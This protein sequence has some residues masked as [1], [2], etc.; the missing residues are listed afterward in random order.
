MLLK[1]Y[2]TLE[3][4]VAGRLQEAGEQ[5]CLAKVVLANHDEGGDATSRRGDP[6]PPSPPPTEE[7]RKKMRVAGIHFVGPNAGEIMQGF[8]VAMTAAAAAN[9]CLRKDDLDRTLEI[10]PTDAEALLQL[11]VTKREGNFVAE[12]GCGGGTCG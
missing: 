3:L 6:S 1:Q 5:T 11:S 4:G 10:H 12:G 8:A 9:S 7:Q 2:S